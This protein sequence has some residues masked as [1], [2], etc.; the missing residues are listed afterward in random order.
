MIENFWLSL[1][2]KGGFVN[3]RVWAPSG[4]LSNRYQGLFPW[5]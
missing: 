1:I 4:L 2:L 5:G 3:V